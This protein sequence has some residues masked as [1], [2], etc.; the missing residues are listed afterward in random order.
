MNT[1]NTTPKTFTSTS[2]NYF[3]QC[4]HTMSHIISRI[5]LTF[6]M[7]RMMVFLVLTSVLLGTL[8]NEYKPWISDHIQLKQLRKTP[9]LG[10]PFYVLIIII[11]L[12]DHASHYGRC[13]PLINTTACDHIFYYTLWS[14]VAGETLLCDAILWSV[15]CTELSK[16]L[17]EARN[18]WSFRRFG[19]VLGWFWLCL[20]G[21]SVPIICLLVW[22]EL[23]IRKVF[24]CLLS[25]SGG[26]YTFPALKFGGHMPSHYYESF[27]FIH[28]DGNRSRYI[29]AD[30][31]ESPRTVCGSKITDLAHF[32][33]HGGGGYGGGYVQEVITRLRPLS[34]KHSMELWWICRGPL[35]SGYRSR[36][37]SGG[38]QRILSIYAW[39]FPF[40]LV[41]GE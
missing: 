26:F 27:K 30:E 6:P 32:S 22:C 5:S 20:R 19:F 16:S 12:C 13:V 24:G 1:A 25:Q 39:M 23:L 11:L 36:P 2:Y 37:Y 28:T 9:A 17:S 7:S 34:V 4:D 35:R 3:Q 10:V 41:L 31:I 15:S 18:F 21:S 38:V 8:N 14:I 33:S 40:N 29:G